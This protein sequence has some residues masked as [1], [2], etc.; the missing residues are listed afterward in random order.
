MKAYYGNASTFP[1]QGVRIYTVTSG[2]S[3]FD[4]VLGYLDILLSAT[5]DG[6]EY[7][8]GELNNQY[9]PGIMLYASNPSITIKYLDYNGGYAEKTA[10]VTLVTYGSLGSS[11]DY[12]DAPLNSGASD[13]NPENVQQLCF[14][15]KK[16]NT[17]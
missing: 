3:P 9:P 17:K 6:T 14:P 4:G 5:I 2:I 7:K 15:V 1:N 8:F 10:S 11:Y 13:R 12:L 16:Q